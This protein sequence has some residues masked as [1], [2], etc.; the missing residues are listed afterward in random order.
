M[1]QQ[2]ITI[3]ID[4][5]YLWTEN[6]RD[7]VDTSFS[8]YEII[9]KAVEDKNLKWE[10][11]KLVNK[12]GK[13]YDFSELPTVV[14]H[15]GK[16]I[17]YDGNRRIAVLKYLQNKE[18]Y[19]SLGGGL[20]FED[21]PLELKELKNIP[22]NVCDK[23]TAL[24]NIERKHVENGTWKALDRDY[25]LYKHRGKAKS[26]FLIIEEN[27]GII[28]TNSKLNQRFVKDEVFSEE[29]LRSI[30]FY[31]NKGQILSSYDLQTSNDILNK[32]V[33][34][35]AKNIVST[36]NNR[37]SKKGVLKSILEKN[38]TIKIE[39]F[40][41]KKSQNISNYPKN[42]NS[43]VRQ[44]SRKTPVS[45]PHKRDILFG[46]TLVL[47]SSAIN[48]LYSGICCLYDKV[49]NNDQNL[50]KT[51]PVF[52]MS[53]RLILDV[54]G[55]EYFKKDAEKANK[56]Q[57]WKDFISVAKKDFKCLN[58]IE[59]LNFL[60]LSQGW[61]ESGTNFEAPLGKWAHGTLPT[62]KQDILQLSYIVGDILEF[63]FKRDNTL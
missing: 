54:A 59:K 3:P 23:Y 49:K 36:R 61:L 48:D 58:D 47:R 16:Y 20:F 14:E 41:P 32:V 43:Y 10:L 33:E 62:S 27:T 34:L 4:K 42:E 39:E 21:E 57:L 53:L 19:Q 1:K 51:L 40:N 26:N 6:P 9:K 22:C 38:T 12:M 35:I 13:Y 28:S 46:R 45:N 31:I 50:F 18:L 11:P 56:D 25:F 24:I 7:P 44:I 17:V 63:Y 52:G 60:S 8:D 55:R 2:I 5:L 37:P 30:G 29:N 15:N